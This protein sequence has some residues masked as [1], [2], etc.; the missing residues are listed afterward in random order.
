[1]AQTTAV[2]LIKGANNLQITDDGTNKRAANGLMLI[3]AMIQEIDDHHDPIIKKARATVEAAREA[4]ARLRD[5]LSSALQIIKDK[6]LAYDKE[7]KDAA[8][9]KQQEEQEEENA[10]VEQERKANL[11]LAKDLRKSGA[12]QQAKI[13]EAAVVEPTK[14][15]LQEPEKIT[16]QAL[17]KTYYADVVDLKS[18]VEAWLRG[19]VPED[20]I[21]VNRVLLGEY[22]RNPDKRSLVE[23]YPGIK[24]D[25]NEGL[26]VK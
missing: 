19:D 4:K 22:V 24:V 8:L 14:I 20:G 18:F 7:S 12:K 6:R 17:R 21:T 10:R 15:E 2:S 26:V 5:P 1:M 13:L 16:G 3:K 9:K 25:F 23:K 11:A